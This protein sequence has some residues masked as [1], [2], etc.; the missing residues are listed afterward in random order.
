MELYEAG[1]YR[2]AMEEFSKAREGS[3]GLP[4]QKEVELDYYLA[5]T[6]A[7][8]LDRRAEQ[9]LEGFLQNHPE[10]IYAN[11]IRF[12]RAN[13]LY[14]NGDF[15]GALAQYREVSPQGLSGEERDEYN[16]KTA[17]SYFRL[18]DHSAA[19]V[20]FRQVS[21]AGKFAVHATYY[22]AYLDYIG[23]N[24]G[25]AKKVFTTLLG[26]AAYGRVIPFYLLQIEFLE[27]NYD[28]VLREGDKLL[29]ASRGERTVE[30]ARIMGESWFHKA[31]YERALYYMDTYRGN[32]GR[33]G[34]EE[35]YLVGFSQYMRNEIP[36]AERSLELVVGPDDRLTQ[37]A[38]YHLGAIYLRTGEKQRAMQSFSIASGSGFDPAIREDALFNYGKLQYELGGGVFN[39]A[40]NVLNRYIAEYP[41]GAR[42]TEAR[43]FLVAA[44][45]NSRN[46]EAAYEAIRQVPDPDN[47]LRTAFQKIAYFRAMEYYSRGDYDSAIR[48]LD[49]SLRNRFNPK[50]TAL[51]QF[52]KGEILYREGKF[53]QSLPLFTEYLSIS[54]ST[55]REYGMAQ[56]NLGYCY[57]N[58]GRYG[59]ARTWF[60][61]FLRGGHA[62]GNLRADALNRVGDCCFATRDFA[63]AISSYEGA[64][65]LG[66]QEKYYARFRRAA[67]LGFTAGTGRK[68]EVLRAIGAPGEGIYVAEA[69]YG[70]GG[71]SL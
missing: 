23:G 51:T 27:G 67:A 14:D 56:Y 69:L 25:S 48:L 13:L 36:E 41:R 6:A 32:G 66:T 47:N 63:G 50:Y 3:Y 62:G 28:Y 45:Y 20:Y 39:E 59:E 10:S 11:D 7:K 30:I 53:D 1:R 4:Y 21:P 35:N 22:A 15:T 33:M 38:A 8:T 37:N 64:E 34:R 57:F 31:N 52:W 65:A 9:R 43:E 61:R 5:R 71:P 29:E 70:L 24:Y 54:P 68:I 44:Y 26:D 12:A 58:M 40:I 42:T 2:A 16:F 55:E 17:Y 60:D 49:E 46:Y 18:N 19:A